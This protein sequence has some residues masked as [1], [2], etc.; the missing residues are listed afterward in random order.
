MAGEIFLPA[1]KIDSGITVALTLV[2][3]VVSTRANS[4]LRMSRTKLTASP[5]RIH[6]CPSTA[7]I[8][9]SSSLNIIKPTPKCSKTTPAR[10]FGTNES[11]MRVLPV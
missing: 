3:S 9:T 10:F 4:S 7:F 11:Q 5:S 1:I 2:G 6:I 8:E